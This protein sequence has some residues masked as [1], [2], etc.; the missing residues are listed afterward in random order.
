MVLTITQ[1]IHEIDRESE[2]CRQTCRK[3]VCDK[4]DVCLLEKMWLV[5]ELDSNDFSKL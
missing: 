5:F 1:V 2:F 4:Q 3:A